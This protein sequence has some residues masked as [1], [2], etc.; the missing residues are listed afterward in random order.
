MNGLKFIK[1][2]KKKVYIEIQLNLLMELLNI[3]I[4]KII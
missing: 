4:N 3:K 2:I 1:K